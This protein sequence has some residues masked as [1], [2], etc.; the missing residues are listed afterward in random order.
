M[1]KIILGLSTLLSVLGFSQETEFKLTKDGFTDFIVTPVEN[2]TQTEMYKKAFD[3]VN[4]TFKNPKEVIKAQIENDYIR[5]EGSS[6][7]LI[8]INILGMKNCYLSKYQIEISFKDGKYKFDVSDLSFYTEPSQY[9]AGGWFPENFSK[10][11]DYF[12]DN[13]DLRGRFKFYN[14]IPSYFNNLNIELKDFLVSDK[15]PSKKNDW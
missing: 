13:G 15:I 10:P 7:S 8:C 2:K 14:E 5:I 11:S 6:N 12:K 4:V 1:K 9:G 3:W